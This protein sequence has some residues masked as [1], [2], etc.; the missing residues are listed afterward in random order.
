MT[1]YTEEEAKTKWCPYA[2]VQVE[3]QGYIGGTG[4][5]NHALAGVN[6]LLDASVR[7]ADCLG[8]ACMAWR[9]VNVNV[10]PPREPEWIAKGY[11]GLAGRPE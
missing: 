4:G 5:S 6:R 3:R 10:G 7:N 1:T 2:R 11:C 8:S 9:K